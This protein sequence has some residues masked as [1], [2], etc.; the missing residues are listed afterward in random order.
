MD[1]D[2]EP[3]S[4]SG[5]ADLAGVT[6]AEIDRMVDLGI[7]VARDST[8]PFLAT[9]AQKVRLATA[10]E[11]AGLPLEGIAAA[12]RAGRLSFAFLEAAPYRRWAMRSP[13]TY[14][15]VSQETGMPLEVLRA[16][17]ESMGL[18]RAAPDELIRE[19]ELEVVPLLQLVAAT[20]NLDLAWTTRVGR[21]YADGLRLIAKVENEAYHA[22]FELPVLEA[23]A[24]QRRAMELAS[25]MSGQFS[26]LIDRALMGIYR[27][28]Q[29]LDRRLHLASRLRQ[30]VVCPPLGQGL[31]LWVDDLTFDLAN[32]VR[33]VQVAAPGGEQE[34]LAL[35]DRL[36]LRLLDR[37]RP[38]WELWL[39]T[40][41]AHGRVGLLFKLHHALAAALARLRHPGRLA[42]QAR[43][44]AR[45]WRMVQELAAATRPLPG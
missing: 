43:V 1:R 28:Q 2:M 6:E 38:L 9:D 37:T 27:R 14:H 45:A 31:P 39:V 26:P 23:G 17:L 40:G 30:L 29:E 42:A 8:G 11:Q 22:R 21:A 41:L 24:D 25:Q 36:G 33:A 20:A 3:L 13:R 34:L 5:L 10:C 16:S 12:I 18:A 7:L 15:Q 35:C 32:H 4:A 44:L 19:D